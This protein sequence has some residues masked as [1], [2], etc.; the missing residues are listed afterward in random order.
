MNISGFTSDKNVSTGQIAQSDFKKYGKIELTFHVNQK[1]GVVGLSIAGIETFQK[2][3]LRPTEI[4]KIK[5]TVFYN[6]FVQKFSNKE[7]FDAII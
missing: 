3:Y 6:K 2:Y 1:L 5:N 4:Q 7:K